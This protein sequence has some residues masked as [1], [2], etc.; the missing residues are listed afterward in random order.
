MSEAINTRLT[1]AILKDEPQQAWWDY[2]DL[3]LVARADLYLAA[4]KE[5]LRVHYA[6]RWDA[7]RAKYVYP[8]GY[9]ADHAPE[10][11]DAQLRNL[12]KARQQA[13][14][15][16][17]PYD[18]YCHLAINHGDLSLWEYLPQIRQMYSQSIVT[19]V[20]ERWCRSLREVPFIPSQPRD[21]DAFNE[22]LVT[23]ASYRPHPK[24][25]IRVF[26]DRGLIDEE[27][28]VSLFGVEQTEMALSL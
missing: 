25:I 19:A 20:Y 1:R 4:Y 22:Y 18:R 14:A 24:F 11:A 26:L 23:I 10:L 9:K 13:D 28:A 8:R 15:L 7:R 17:I 16:C 21:S 5:A 6:R 27:R 2:L 3:G 12:W